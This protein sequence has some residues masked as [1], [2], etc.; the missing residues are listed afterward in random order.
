M[1]YQ[2]LMGH[3]IPNLIHSLGLASLFNISIFMDYL[4][5]KLSLYKNNCAIIKS[6]AVTEEV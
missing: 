1:A 2:L 3:L 6:I 5:P 4:V